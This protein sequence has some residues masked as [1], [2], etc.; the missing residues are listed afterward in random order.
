MCIIRGGWTHLKNRYMNMNSCCLTLRRHKIHPALC[1]SCPVFLTTLVSFLRFSF[2]VSSLPP[3]GAVHQVW[4]ACPAEFHHQTEGGGGQRGAETEEKV[5]ENTEYNLLVSLFCFAFNGHSRHCVHQRILFCLHLSARTYRYTYLRCI[6]EKQL[7]CLPEG[8]TC[9]W[10]AHQTVKGTTS[11]TQLWPRQW[12][13]IS[14]QQPQCMCFSD[15]P[16]PPEFLPLHGVF[17]QNHPI[18]QPTHKTLTCCIVCMWSGTTSAIVFRH[19]HFFSSLHTVH[20]ERHSSTH[21]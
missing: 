17:F 2:Y 10:S 6:I 5:Q 3:G 15:Y 13:R 1:L 4:N 14:W 19:N 21:E 8:A 18:S 16:A 20:N 9:M 12:P 7:R 11:S